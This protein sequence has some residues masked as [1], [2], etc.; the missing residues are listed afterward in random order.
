[1][2]RISL[3]ALLILTLVVAGGDAQLAGGGRRV[4]EALLSE[5]VE[6]KRRLFVRYPWLDPTNLFLDVTVGRKDVQ[7]AIEVVVEEE[8]AERE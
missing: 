3:A 8:H 7:P 6:E 2:M 1:M 4:L 5:V